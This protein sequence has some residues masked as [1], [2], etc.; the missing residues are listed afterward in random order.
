MR[1]TVTGTSATHLRAGRLHQSHTYTV[2]AYNTAGESAAS[3]A[4]T[5]TTTGCPAAAA[6]RAAPYLYLGW[7]NPPAPATVMW[8][9]GIRWFTMAFMLSGGGCTPAWDGSRPLTGGVDQQAINAIRAAGGDIQISFG[10]WSG[11]KLGPNCSTAAGARRRVPAGHQR[12]QPEGIDI[13]IENTDE[14]EN[15]VVQDRILERAEDRQA[16]QPGHQ[17]DRHVRHHARPARPTGASG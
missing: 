1:A 9:T 15:E 6:P 10:G 7:G 13:D 4:V 14:F 17:D 12:V 8:A 5:G 11:N 2:A 16:E 3:D